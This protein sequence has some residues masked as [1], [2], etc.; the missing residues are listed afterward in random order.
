MAE[1]DLAARAEALPSVNWAHPPAEV[2]VWIAE[3]LLPGGGVVVAERDGHPVCL[4]PRFAA[5]ASITL[6]LN[7]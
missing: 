2:R 6:G 3:I 4:A 5:S 1:I 7:D